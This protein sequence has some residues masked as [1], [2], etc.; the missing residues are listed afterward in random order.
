MFGWLRKKARKRSLLADWN[1]G[2]LS[3]FERIVNESSIQYYHE[4]TG[5]VI[6][7]STLV[8]T[9]SG[10]LP[11]LTNHLLANGVSI[12]EHDD[13]WHLKGRKSH[14]NVILVCV[15][16]VV[17]KADLDWAEAFFNSIRLENA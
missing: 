13:Q 7:F 6:Y 16:S 14:A 1:F 11:D 10:P 12:E 15:I 5:R 9:G 4:P 17:E 3:E 8:V 2:D